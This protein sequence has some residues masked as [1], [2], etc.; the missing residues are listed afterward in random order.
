[1]MTF[2][3]EN[4]GNVKRVYY[5]ISDFVYLFLSLHKSEN[6]IKKQKKNLQVQIN[7]FSQ[8]FKSVFWM[9]FV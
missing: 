1:M 5:I 6:T 9:F 2:T 8:I 3:S 4:P 7:K